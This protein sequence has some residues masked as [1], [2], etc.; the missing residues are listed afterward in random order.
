MRVRD[1]KEADWWI[2]FS[3]VSLLGIGIIMVFSSSQ[4]VAQFSPFNDS[5]FFLK[6]QCVNAAVGLA[7]MFFF[8]KFKYSYLKKLAPLGFIL[9]IVLLLGAF[10]FGVVIKG[11]GRWFLGLQPSELCK[12]ALVIMLAKVLSENL[13]KIKDFKEGFLPPFILMA[14]SCVL[15][16]LGKDLGSM[17]IIAATALLLM[18][19][20]GVSG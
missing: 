12:L 10:F 7:G 16:L 5:L 6:R 15:V 20:A 3:V 19:C 2:F 9:V 13:H 8:Y 11:A 14:V 4:Y 17:M 1:K 18:F